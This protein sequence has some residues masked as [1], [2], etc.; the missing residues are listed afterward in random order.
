MSRKDPSNQEIQEAHDRRAKAFAPLR[1][2]QLTAETPLPDVSAQLSEEAKA[3]TTPL[4]SYAAL[5]QELGRLKAFI[6]EH[7][8]YQRTGLTSHEAKV[9]VAAS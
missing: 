4:R 3:P 1:E 9:A 8:M 7:E 2:M 6:A 5:L